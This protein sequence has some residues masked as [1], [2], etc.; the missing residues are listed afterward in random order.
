MSNNKCVK[1]NE[2]IC[3]NFVRMKTLGEMNL[4]M[5]IHD[6]EMYD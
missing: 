4:S 6:E 5:T 1:T 2:K 3:K